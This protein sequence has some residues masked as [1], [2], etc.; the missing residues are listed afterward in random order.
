MTRVQR[1]RQ[2]LKTIAHDLP[3]G[4]QAEFIEDTLYVTGVMPDE[5]R[6]ILARIRDLG[7]RVSMSQ[8][9]SY[10]TDYTFTYRFVA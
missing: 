2:I 8:S 3:W 1:E 4:G 10:Q 7:H 6:A 5:G 9:G